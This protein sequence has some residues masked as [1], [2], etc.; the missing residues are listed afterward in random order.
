[1]KR[2]LG[3]NSLLPQ[4]IKDAITACKKLQ[5]RNLWVDRL[6]ILQDEEPNTRDLHLNAMGEIYGN[7]YSTLVA[8]AGNDAEYGLPGVDSIKQSPK[9]TGE[10]Q[11]M[12]MSVELNPYNEFLR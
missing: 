8:M 4:T 3:G 6:C 12:Y 5:I 10:I 1:M 9:W 2:C 11:N 7:S